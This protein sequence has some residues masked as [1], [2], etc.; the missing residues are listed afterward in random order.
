MK[1][2]PFT[3]L[4]NLV[5]LKG[6]LFP[7]LVGHLLSW[8][9]LSSRTDWFIFQ[10]FWYWLWRKSIASMFVSIVKM[11]FLSKDS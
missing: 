10:G 5:C 1:S 3:Y 7:R 2:M 8:S 6:I 4:E 11:K 9:Y